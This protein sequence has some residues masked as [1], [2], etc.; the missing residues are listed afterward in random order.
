MPTARASL[1]VAAVNGKIYAIGGENFSAYFSTNE[2][3]DPATDT[4]TTKK[5]MPTSRSGLAVAVYQNKIYAFGGMA[6]RPSEVS[7]PFLG[8]TE[9]YDPET[10]MWETKTQMP[11]RRAWLCANVV[12]DK[13]YLIGGNTWW[14]PPAFTAETDLV[15]V[16]DPETDLWTT[17][18]SIPSLIPSYPPDV[19]ASAVVD[20]KIYVVSFNMNPFGSFP[21]VNANQVYDP[22]TDT[23]SLGDSV[24]PPVVYAAAGATTGIAAPKRIYVLGGICPNNSITNLNRVYDP[25]GDAWSAGA[26]MPT[27]RYRLG[28]T[29]VSDVLYAIGGVSSGLG[30][31]SPVAVNERYTPDTTSPAVR[32][33]S[34]ENKTYT[35]NNISL[36][37]TLS[38]SIS[39]IGYTLN[40]QA[41]VTIT[42]NT[43]LTGL[44]NGLHNLT[45]YATDTDGNTGVSETVYFSVKAP[46]SAAFPTIEA[47]AA[48][49]AITIIIAL[50]AAL[51]L[52][53]KHK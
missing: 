49:A 27:A 47:A 51:I 18:A 29:I 41:N 22:E 23:W 32:V 52:K 15:E 28:V 7:D 37:F 9:V 24:P 11:T 45:V 14:A 16:Y 38:E 10:D 39:W 12:K 40:D 50:T 30:S 19:V 34:P 5:P 2:E 46:E 31:S 4:W 20:N 48:A 35:V 13:I 36:T 53:K 6:G 33:V 21:T 25:E 17:R 26:A 42:G 3:Y 1:G 43:T 8:A 44:S